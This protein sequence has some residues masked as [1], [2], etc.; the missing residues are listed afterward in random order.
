[1]N[2]YYFHLIKQLN[3]RLS[4]IVFFAQNRSQ[5]KSVRNEVMFV[6]TQMASAMLSFKTLRA[7]QLRIWCSELLSTSHLLRLES[8]SVYK[9]LLSA[10]HSTLRSCSDNRVRTHHLN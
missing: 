1:M 2:Y 7:S 9:E 8:V 4:H 3:K 10:T 5:N 6:L